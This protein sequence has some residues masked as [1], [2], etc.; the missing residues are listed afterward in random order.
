LQYHQLQQNHQRNISHL[1]FSKSFQHFVDSFKK[2]MQNYGAKIYFGPST[3]CMKTLHKY[4]QYFT[5]RVGVG[6]GAVRGEC[7]LVGGLKGCYWWKAV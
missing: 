5:L 1:N 3:Y 7:V 2:G 6:S 4:S